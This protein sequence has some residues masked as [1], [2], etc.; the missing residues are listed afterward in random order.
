MRYI[1]T[2]IVATLVLVST[3]TADT[4]TIAT[5]GMT[6]APA[7][8]DVQPGDII[9]FEV[10][11]YHTATSGSS[12]SSDGLFDYGSGTNTWTVPDSVAGTTVDYFCIPHC[13]MG[14]TG[15][16][17][18]ADTITVCS[19]GCDYTSINDAIDAASDGDV[20][21]LSSQTY[22]EGVEIN[23]EGKAITISGTTDADGNSTSILDG[24]N[25]HRVLICQT[26]EGADTVFENLVVRNGFADNGGG[27]RNGGSRPTLTNCTFTGNVA[28]QYGGGV[29][30]LS[31]WSIMTNCTFTG[32]EA[33]SGG[34]LYSSSGNPTL[35][36]CTF[37][38]NEAGTGDGGGVLLSF[39]NPTLENCTFTGNLANHYG[40]GMWITSSSSPIIITC[41]FE[42]N[43]ATFNGG[44]LYSGFQC[45]P[46][47]TDTTVC[48]NTTDQIDGD[49]TDNGGNTVADEC[50]D[51]CTGDF[52]DNGE[53]SVDD[54]LAL[55]AAYQTNA[56]GDCDGDGDTD[57]D[58]LLLLISAWGVCP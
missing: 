1:C 44:A 20:I 35:T 30:G 36:N 14:M 24:N 16:I 26:G 12:C 3:S 17:N 48:G 18:V 45:N 2:S 31:S 39:S 11:P 33:P 52:D 46:S 58:D 57:V 22:Y 28:Q 53:V 25:S 47:L 37:T 21:Q 19:S 34:G 6:F 7:T 43:S 27:M 41:R 51:D 50:P 40:G 8:L 13:S 54:L 56:D 38:G 15:A 55:L 32:N 23:T 9:T 49:W 42:G 5:N 4:Y 10:G 29:Q